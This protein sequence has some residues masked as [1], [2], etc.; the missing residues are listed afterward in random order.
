MVSARYFYVSIDRSIN[1]IH[2]PRILNA[3][4]VFYKKYVFFLLTDNQYLKLDQ[5]ETRKSN[6][7]LRRFSKPP[8][9]LPLGTDAVFKYTFGTTEADK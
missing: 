1:E 4:E 3:I 7:P 2:K 5:S 8:V 9:G 6:I